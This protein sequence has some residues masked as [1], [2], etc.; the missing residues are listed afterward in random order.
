MFTG[1]STIGDSAIYNSLGGKVGIGTTH[2]AAILDVNGTGNFTGA[3]T[4]AAGAL[5]PATGTA[6]ATQGLNSNPFDLIASSFNSGTSA[7]VPQL[8]RWMAEPAGNNTAS[9]SATLNL[10]FLSG[11]GTPAE[12][13]LSIGGNGQINFATGQTFPGTGTITGVNPGIDLTGGGGSG[14]VTL[15]LDTTKVPTL[16][17]VS[18]TFTGSITASSFT[19]D[20][21]GL[22]N[23]NAGSL[24]GV[25]TSGF[26][27]LGANN[28]F[29]GFETF[30]GG[31]V[32]PF[33]LIA[34]AAGGTP[35]F[36]L[37]V[38]GGNASVESA[39]ITSHGTDAAISLRNT[40]GLGVGSN[41]G[42]E[43]WLD[44]GANTAGVGAG[45][46]AVWDN[47]TGAARLV[48]NPVGNV[49]IG[50]I[51]PYTALHVL[52][53]APGTLGPSLTLMNG[54]AGAGAGGSV[55]F[56]GYDPT[57]SNPPTARIQSIDD[58]NF[59][60]NL[61]FSTKAPGGVGNSLVEQVRVS[62]YGSLIV[63]SS[64]NNQFF[65]SASNAGGTGLVFGGSGSGEGIASCRASQTACTDSTFLQL[66]HQYGLDFYSN[67][68]VVGSFLNPGI[69]ASY[70]EFI[71][72]GNS[73]FFGCTDWQGGDSQGE[74][75]SDARLKTNIQPFPAVLDRLVQLRPVHFDWNRSLYPEHHFSPERQTGLIAQDVEKVFP[76]MVTVGEDG[77]RKV[78]YG[79]LPYLLLQGVRELK[80]RNDSLRAEVGGLERASAQKDVQIAAMSRQIEQLRQAQEQ[81]R[82]V[83]A[84]LAHQQPAQA[85]N[86][87]QAEIAKLQ[88]QLAAQRKE[89]QEQQVQLE[90]QQAVMAQ[91]LEQV[92]VIQSRLDGKTATR[93]RIRAAKKAATRAKTP[94]AA[95]ANTNDAVHPLVAK[96]GF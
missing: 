59:S 41:A 93:P 69:Y 16:G 96:V 87:D 20:G 95:P 86:A 1:S 4:A 35:Q 6:T 54:G 2:P 78:N 22:T 29:D 14:T 38:Q 34:G 88:S 12:T 39:R 18:N 82:V 46:F 3:L 80:A 32:F 9:P 64:H 47:T 45:N 60:S 5:L 77:Y 27:Q 24:G 23:V 76:Y 26:A 63:D 56:D 44:S 57:S 79:Q 58:G 11:F 53:N 10:Q 74:C 15:N 73:Y 31:A 67:H 17:A 42:R 7:A 50:T 62:D 13:G 81:M 37:D 65:L 8:F 28:D 91:L 19:G 71:V 72:Y 36:P 40:Y 33:G 30:F 90:K 66:N 94:K 83:V 85:R 75:N 89:G 61:T 92:R 68:N 49:G 25:A 84:R 51:N 48:V 55:D 43:Y 21:S 52:Q 70:G